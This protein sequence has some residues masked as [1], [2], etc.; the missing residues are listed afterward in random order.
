MLLH[1]LVCVLQ[2]PLKKFADPNYGDRFDPS[3]RQMEKLQARSLTSENLVE[4]IQV[5]VRQCYGMRRLNVKPT[6]WQGTSL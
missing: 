1:E 4:I 3:Q 6:A 5:M 2:G